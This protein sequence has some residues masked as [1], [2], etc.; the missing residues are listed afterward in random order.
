MLMTNDRNSPGSSSQLLTGPLLEAAPSLDDEFHLVLQAE[1]AVLP[2]HLPAH[3]LAASLINLIPAN[4]GS[5]QS[6]LHMRSAS[7]LIAMWLAK[8]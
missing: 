5:R 8:T 7:H 2:C 6:P 4:S 3:V 1:K